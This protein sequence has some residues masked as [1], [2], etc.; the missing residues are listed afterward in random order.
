MGRKQDHYLAIVPLGTKYGSHS[1]LFQNNSRI[2][3]KNSTTK[4]YPVPNGT[5][6]IAVT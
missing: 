5:V 1:S 3:H 4:P 2:S 6:V